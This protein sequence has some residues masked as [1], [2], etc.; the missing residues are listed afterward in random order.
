MF[1]RYLLL[2]IVVGL[3]SGFFA[4]LF[5]LALELVSSLVLEGIVGYYQ[6]LPAGE[7]ERDF[8]TPYPLH[9]YLLPVTVAIGGLLSGIITYLFAPESAGVGTDAAIKA[10][11]EGKRLSLRSSVVK[12]VT[13][14]ITIGTGGT[15]GREGPIA[16]IGAG[17]GSFVAERM[18]LKERER[19][20]A[21]AIGLGAGIAA[22]FKA[23]LAGAIISA[24]VFFKRDFY[25]ET[26]I[27]SFIASVVSYSLFGTVFGFQP[28]FSTEIPPFR[29]VGLHGLL[30]YVGL[31]LLCALAVRIYVNLFFGVSSFFRKLSLPDYVKPALGGLLAGMVGALVPVAIGNGYGWLQLVMDGFV[32]DYLFTFLGALA[33]M[34]GVSFT[35]GSGGSG[36][37][38]GPSVMIG[39]LLGASYSLFLNSFYGLSL[40]VPSFTI[41]GMVALFAGAAKAPLSTLILV[42]EMTGGYELLVPAMISVFITYFLS[43]ER[44][45]FPSQVDTRMD[46]PAHMDEC[47]LYILEKLKVRDY[48]SRPY[49]L[50]PWA[51]VDEA[52]RLM[53]EKLIGG[54]P[55]VEGSRLVGIVTRGDV[56]KVREEERATKRLEEIMTRQVVTVGP[57][58]SLAE[59]LRLMTT[60]GFGRVPVVERGRLV[61][62]I[63]RADLGRAVREKSFRPSQEKS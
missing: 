15:S 40:H 46:S 36:G 52:M 10:Y 49:T 13:S 50:P 2:P 51:T 37:V 39:G 56:V 19:R 23:P 31:G 58:D 43:G 61:G 63:A 3:L 60:R 62:I 45:I 7:G 24:E 18:G 20:V 35:I 57:E 42:A 14:A 27:P 22:I 41:V 48:M 59:V 8:F 47:G 28:I 1:K 55:V 9:P 12:L 44:S 34:L 53:A 16:L 32:K 4:V 11:H 21:L 5:V 29:E 17:I 25:I 6:P 54:I 38:F 30:A 26:M 33:V